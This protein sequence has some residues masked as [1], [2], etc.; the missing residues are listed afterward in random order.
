[1]PKI[2]VM[3]PLC[4]TVEIT[5]SSPQVDATMDQ[6]RQEVAAAGG[7]VFEAPGFVAAT[8]PMILAVKSSEELPFAGLSIPDQSGAA[9]E[10]GHDA[11]R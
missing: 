6:I 8:V 3:V 11:S 9:E 4:G 2:I 1:M 7:V 5:V 10:G